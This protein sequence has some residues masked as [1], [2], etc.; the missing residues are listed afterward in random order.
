MTTYVKPLQLIRAHNVVSWNTCYTIMNSCVSDKQLDDQKTDGTWKLYHS[1][2]QQYSKAIGKIHNHTF[3]YYITHLQITIDNTCVL[4]KAHRTQLPTPVFHQFLLW[5]MW[6]HKWFTKH[7]QLT[8]E[9][10]VSC[11]KIRYDQALFIQF[12]PMKSDRF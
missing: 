8:C 10:F 5:N 12:L 4:Q 9:I 7:S 6:E 1:L 2:Q 11:M 3:I